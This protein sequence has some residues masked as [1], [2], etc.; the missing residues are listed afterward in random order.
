MGVKSSG[1][2]M[3]Y[4]FKERLCCKLDTCCFLQNHIKPFIARHPLLVAEVLARSSIDR[5]GGFKDY[6]EEWVYQA[7]FA[8]NYTAGYLLSILRK[9]L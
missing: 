9:R 2:K 6:F 4:A 3:K 1:N 5:F 7:T 8:P